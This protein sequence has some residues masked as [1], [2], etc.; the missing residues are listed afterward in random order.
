MNNTDLLKCYELLEKITVDKIMLKEKL[1]FGNRDCAKA[2]R[3]LDDL[4]IHILD[5]LGI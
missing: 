5:L 4:E 3:K 2:I 1:D